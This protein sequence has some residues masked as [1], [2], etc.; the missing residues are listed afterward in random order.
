MIETLTIKLVHDSRPKE[1]QWQ[2]TLE[3]PV[4]YSLEDLH[5]EIQAAVN[6]DNDHLYEFYIAKTHSSANA[7]VIQ[8]DYNAIETTTIADITLKMKGKKLFYLFDYG[9]NWLFQISKSRK[10]PFEPKARA[11]YPRIAFKQGRKPKQYAY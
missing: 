2:C 11:I 8:C 6:F 7:E 4:D 5:Y 1:K 10:K 9:D 3:I